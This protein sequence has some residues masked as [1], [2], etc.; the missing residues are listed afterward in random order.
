RLVSAKDRPDLGA[1]EPAAVFELGAVEADVLV[2]RLAEAADHQRIGERPGLAG[3]VD[4]AAEPDPGFLE[5]LAPHRALDRLAGLYEAGQRRIHAWRKMLAAAEQAALL[6]H[7]QHDGHRI[8]TREMLGAAV[9]AM[10]LVAARTHLALVP[11]FG[12]EAVAGM[13]GQQ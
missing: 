10:A 2:E 6:R 9:R 13:P 3:V 11:A 12:A 7:R 5:G 1:R 8:G 4:Y